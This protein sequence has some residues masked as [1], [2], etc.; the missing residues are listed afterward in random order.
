MSKPTLLA[1]LAL[2]LAQSPEDVATE[3][4]TL[5][6][7]RSEAAR[8]AMNSLIA[9]WSQS[10]GHAITRWR[11]QVVGLDD[12]RTDME[13]EDATG[14]VQV[15]L[16]NKFW[17]GLTPNQPA[18]YLKRLPTDCGLL[19]FVV[20][21]TRRSVIEIELIERASA[22]GVDH[23]AFQGAG[24]S[25]VAKSSGSHT[26]VVTSWDVILSTIASSLE[27]AHDHT[28]L[29]D[30]RQLQGL[31]ERM[32][33]EGF[34][35]FTATDVTGPTPR[36][37]LQ[38]Y[39]VV[40]EVW[41]RLAREPFVDYKGLAKAVGPGWYGPYFR[42]HGLR[43]GLLFTAH[44]WA[45]FGV[46]PIWLWV[47][48]PDASLKEKVRIRLSALLHDPTWLRQEDDGY[49]AG[50]WLP[51]RL[52]EGRDR[53]A[54]A[55]DVVHQVEAVASALGAQVIPAAQIDPPGLVG[56]EPLKPDLTV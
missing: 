48:T 17:A 22:C 33:T 44:R 47:I 1:D 54:V 41:N 53:D 21:E 56:G 37:L 2:R 9:Q 27:A 36:V 32:D 8:Q 52:L 34:L 29:A 11:A 23:F 40:D 39:Q 19:A 4:L 35:P 14:V 26:V 55:A 28:A 49:F 51:I 38:C 50:L 6:L 43:C 3:A 18:T 25:R 15:I 31:A 24:A 7:G 30:I 10:E 45:R 42:V 13:G 20:P 46:S 16:E 12:S 5:I